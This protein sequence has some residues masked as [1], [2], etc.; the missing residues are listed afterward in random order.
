MLI[1][2]RGPANLSTHTFPNIRLQRQLEIYLLFQKTL[3]IGCNNN[4]YFHVHAFDISKKSLSYLT[5]LSRRG[6]VN[7]LTPTF[8]NDSL[9]ETTRN[10]IVA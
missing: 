4:L 5:S 2:R 8:R 6:P 3:K 7:T 10:L 9:T 1:S